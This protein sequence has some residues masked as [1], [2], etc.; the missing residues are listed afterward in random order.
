MWSSQYRWGTYQEE[1][2]WTP[3]V[4]TSASYHGCVWSY[5]I[6]MEA[7]FIAVCRRSKMMSMGTR[8]SRSGARLCRRCALPRRGDTPRLRQ[9]VRATTCEKLSDR[10]FLL[11]RA[12]LE[13]G[14]Q[15]PLLEELGLH[16]PQLNAGLPISQTRNRIARVDRVA[17]GHGERG[18]G[19]FDLR[20]DLGTVDREDRKLPPRTPARWCRPLPSSGPLRT[21]STPV[22]APH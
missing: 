3:I 9:I 1:Y 2:V 18:N 4:F 10:D 22:P 15:R 8:R 6:N 16:L 17:F 5:R 20:T 21:A 14:E 19:P 7:Q 11:A 13:H 12:E